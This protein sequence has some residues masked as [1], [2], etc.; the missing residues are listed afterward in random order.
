MFSLSTLSCVPNRR[1]NVQKTL[2]CVPKK[3]CHFANLLVSNGKYHDN[4]P[5]V[6]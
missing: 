3:T 5:I 6:V 1:K 4:Y 2:S